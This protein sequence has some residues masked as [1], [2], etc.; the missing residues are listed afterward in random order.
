MNL[1]TPFDTS[2]HD[3]VVYELKWGSLNLFFEL[4]AHE[5]KFKG[6]FKKV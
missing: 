2:W 4:Q 1:K 6:V 3:Y 5:A